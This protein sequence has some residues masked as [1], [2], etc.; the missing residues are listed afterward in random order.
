M[1]IGQVLGNLLSN[2]IKYGEKGSEI[3]V[4]LHRQDDEVDIAVTNHG[5]GIDPEDLPRIFS[6]F[7][8]SKAAHGSGVRGL[9][10]GLYIAKG[11]VAAHG[12]RMWVESVPGETTT[13][14]VA[15]PTANAKQ[16]AA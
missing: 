11:V 4:R 5:K 7:M 8:R 13:F 9:G 6:R 2:A 3:V 10:L 1:R 16:Q 12:G 15:L 14:H